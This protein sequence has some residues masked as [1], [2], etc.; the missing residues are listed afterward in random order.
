M[1][2]HEPPVRN[3]PY[4]CRDH[5]ASKAN[6]LPHPHPAESR[7]PDAFPAHFQL[8]SSDVEGVVDPL[9]LESWIAAFLVKESPERRLQMKE[10]L[11]AGVLR[12]LVGPGKL[13]RL[14]GVELFL[15]S[16]AVDL[17]FRL[18]TSLPFGQAPVPGEARDPARFPEVFLLRRFGSRRIWCAS[19]TMVFTLSALLPLP[20]AFGSGMSESR[21]SQRAGRE[22]GD[23]FQNILDRFLLEGGPPR[24]GS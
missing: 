16:Q 8:V 5:L 22:H 10:G 20:P 1:N 13:E 6:L 11:L 2:A 7:D 18:V 14:S 3:P 9:S 24:P 19:I 15:Q 17:L 21:T 4:R 12:N 23:D